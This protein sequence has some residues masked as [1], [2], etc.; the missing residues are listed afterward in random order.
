MP[1]STLLVGSIPLGNAAEVFGAIS[2]T[3]GRY[4]SRLPDGETGERSNW[5]AW[6]RKVFA[7]VPQLEPTEKRER[8]YQLSPPFRLKPSAKAEDVVFGPLGFYDEAIRSY[9]AFTRL[10]SEGVIAAGKR[11]QLCLPT[12][13][14]PAFSFIAYQSQNE[15]YP[16]YEAAV[17]SELTAIAKAIPANELAVQWDIAT[18][19]SIWEELYVPTFT[20]WRNEVIRRIVRLGEAVPEGAELGY[21]LC[22]GSMNNKHWK[23]PVDTGKLVEVANLVTGLQQRHIDWWHLPVPIDR[24]DVAYFAPLAH[25]ERSPATELYLGLLHL[26]DGVSGAMRRATAARQFVNSFG[27]SAECGL[28]RWNRE[29]VPDWLALHRDAAE[30]IL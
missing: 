20:D 27:I 18:E 26:S 14:A 5:I 21:H 10:K 3:L 19:M 11:F 30:K 13:F 2:S 8:D 9:S 23:E 1:T 7:A 29:V 17:L 28:G 24:D 12:P 6:Q 15:I 22:Y 25:F 4:L 16:R